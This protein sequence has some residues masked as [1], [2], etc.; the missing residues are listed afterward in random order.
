MFD[1]QCHSPIHQTIP[2]KQDINRKSDLIKL[3]R[4]KKSYSPNSLKAGIIKEFTRS[5]NMKHRV[6]KKNDTEKMRLHS[7]NLASGST[8]TRARG[9]RLRNN[10]IASPCGFTQ[11]YMKRENVSTSLAKEKPRITPNK[12]NLQNKS[13][14]SPLR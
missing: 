9:R 1:S 7:A 12:K 11:V 14:Q 3:K 8:F 6:G 4:P 2:V 5:V 10:A 13:S